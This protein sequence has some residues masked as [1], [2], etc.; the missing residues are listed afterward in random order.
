M[1]QTFIF[2]SDLIEKVNIHDIYHDYV[3]LSRRRRAL[4]RS[5]SKKIDTTEKQGEPKKT[6]V[7]IEK[8][9]EEIGNVSFS[10]L[11]SF[12]YL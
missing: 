3:I 1:K 8:E 4:S 12:N 7:L 5:Q 9:K 6:Q 10:I 2:K 11:L